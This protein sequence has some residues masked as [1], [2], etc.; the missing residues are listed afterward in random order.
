MAGVRQVYW[1]CWSHTSD[2]V[3]RY[4]VYACPL[5]FVLRLQRLLCKPSLRKLS[6][7]HAKLEIDCRANKTTIGCRDG[8]LLRVHTR[9]AC[10]EDTRHT[11]LVHRFNDLQ[12][13]PGF[14]VGGNSPLEVL[15]DIRAEELTDWLDDEKSQP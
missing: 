8:K 12:C 2:G 3:Q 13:G 6:A 15:Y 7:A 10:T 5:R 4:L 14:R 1:K 11:C 9:I